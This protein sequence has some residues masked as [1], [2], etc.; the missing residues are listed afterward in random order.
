MSKKT[1][2]DRVVEQII[3]DICNY[4]D[5]AALEEFLVLLYSEKTHQF[6]KGYI[7]EEE[8]KDYSD[9]DD[10]IKSYS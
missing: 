9:F 6:Y 7:P 8:W 2:I 3:D 1:I 10:E 4:N 5:T